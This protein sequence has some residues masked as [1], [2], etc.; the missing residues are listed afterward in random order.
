MKLGSV[1][2]PTATDVKRYLVKCLNF[3]IARPTL[4]MEPFFMVEKTV[5]KIAVEEVVVELHCPWTSVDS[6][7]AA[8]CK[9][10]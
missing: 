1:S 2:I 10:K 3:T 5:G 7:V 4:K 9:K 6:F 8:M